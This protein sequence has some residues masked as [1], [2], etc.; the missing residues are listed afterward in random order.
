MNNRLMFVSPSS[1]RT[2][3]YLFC[4]AF[5]LEC[6]VH[7]L[8]SQIRWCKRL[9]GYFRD[10]FNDIIKLISVHNGEKNP[11]FSFRCLPGYD[12][13]PD[14]FAVQEI[15]NAIQVFRSYDARN[16]I[17]KGQLFLYEHPISTL[18]TNSYG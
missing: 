12:G 6:L 1:A 17:S 2:H 7:L 4:L 10:F 9:E 13:I 11:L 16:H 14:V 8:S 15:Q 5:Q 3:Q 18:I